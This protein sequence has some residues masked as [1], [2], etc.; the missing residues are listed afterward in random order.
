MAKKLQSNFIRRI[1]KSLTS[2]RPQIPTPGT[3]HVDD[4]TS[5]TSNML[6][7][8]ELGV[9]LTCGTV[10]T[11]DGETGV[12]PNTEDAILDG[13]VLSNVGTSGTYLA[14]SDGY[15]RLKGRTYVYNTPSLS[16]PSSITIESSSGAAGPRIDTIVA[17]PSTNYNSVEDL[18]ELEISVIKGDVF[19]PGC[20]ATKLWPPQVQ[21]PSVNCGSD[22]ILLGFVLVP[23]NLNQA[24]TPIYP[25]SVVDA[26]VDPATAQPYDPDAIGS[27]YF[28]TFPMPILSTNDFIRRRQRTNFE[29]QPN[30]LYFEKQLVYIV[31]TGCGTLYEVSETYQSSSS[32]S[33]DISSGYLVEF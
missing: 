18:Y 13:L 33:T 31:T 11:Q 30:T 6:Y 15:A 26:T 23:A 28:T 32:S 21:G 25:L 20:S 12:Q 7:Q 3:N 17:T 5:W 10:W 27:G 14:V 16:N 22:Y 19:A 24:T 8:G 1:E 9:N 2:I 4:A 29:W